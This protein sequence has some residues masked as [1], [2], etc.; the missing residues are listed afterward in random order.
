MHSVDDPTELE[1]S[2]SK[3]PGD[4]QPLEPE[5]CAGMISWL[6]ELLLSKRVA[7]LRR[8]LSGVAHPAYGEALAAMLG[9]F[10]YKAG[11]LVAGFSG[12]DVGGPP[13]QSTTSSQSNNIVSI[14]VNSNIPVNDNYPRR[15][16]VVEPWLTFLGE[17]FKD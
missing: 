7:V 15:V 12:T 14:P 5:M 8:Y 11:V 6:S 4:F 16:E 13:S 17:V 1:S 10:S 3:A 9:F 2:S